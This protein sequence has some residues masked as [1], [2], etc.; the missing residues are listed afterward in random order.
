MSC[1]AWTVSAMASLGTLPPAGIVTDGEPLKNTCWLEPA[2]RSAPCTRWPT[3]ALPMVTGAELNVLSRRMRMVSPG[4]V[5]RAIMRTVA[6][7]MVAAVTFGCCD[8]PQAV[9]QCAPR[10]DS[11]AQADAQSRTSIGTGIRRRKL[12]AI[13]DDMRHPRS[14]RFSGGSES[15]PMRTLS[16]SPT[17][18]GY[19]ATETRVNARQVTRAASCTAS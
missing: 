5:T 8:V 19:Y 13:F 17:G 15:N 16:G 7:L 12:Q 14:F 3:D 10:S 6:L 9:T 4:R 18:A 1:Q 11:S 2:A